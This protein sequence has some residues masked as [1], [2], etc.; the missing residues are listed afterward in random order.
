M[1]IRALSIW[2]YSWALVG[3]LIGQILGG[4]DGFLLCLTA[5]VVIEYLTGVLAAAQQQRLSSAQGFR[6]ILR[7]ILIFIVVAM[8]HLLDTTLL[9]GAGAP[10]RSAM[11][12]FYIANEGLSIIENLAALGVPIPK[13]L[14]Q[15]LNELGDEDDPPPG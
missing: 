15:V 5:F 1:P 9:G 6:G 10:L 14:K 12:F 4:W 8:G 11:I 13:R 3:D 7:K 2:R